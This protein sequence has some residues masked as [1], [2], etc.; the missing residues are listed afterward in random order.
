[1]DESRARWDVLVNWSLTTASS[2]TS[3]SFIPTSKRTRPENLFWRR[4]TDSVTTDQVKPLEFE[5]FGGWT[6]ETHEFLRSIIKGIAADNNSLFEKLWR[7]LRTKI[8][9]N[10]ARGEGEM[11]L[12]L[13]ERNK[14]GTAGQ[15]ASPAPR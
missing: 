10:L 14:V 15:A 3:V 7:Q 11:I 1:R 2:P 6:N 13:N 5:T 8:A 12:C 4:P 9:V